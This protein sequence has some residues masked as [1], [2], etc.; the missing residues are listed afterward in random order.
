MDAA[1]VGKLV[2][3]EVLNLHGLT[4]QESAVLVK[5]DMTPPRAILLAT[6]SGSP[7]LVGNTA[8]AGS[9]QVSSGYIEAA[10]SLFANR[11]RG[12]L[13][14]NRGGTSNWFKQCMTANGYCNHVAFHLHVHLAVGLL[15]KLNLQTAAELPA[16]HV[17]GQF[18][19][20]HV[21]AMWSQQRPR[22]R[23]S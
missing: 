7:M 8:S 6:L 22:T 16:T 17:G 1:P 9:N 12:T 3:N 18:H 20:R 10:R 4:G 23:R 5:L 14:D 2:V 19:S 13:I 21:T 11:E 15:R